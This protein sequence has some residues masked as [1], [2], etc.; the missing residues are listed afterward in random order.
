MPPECVSLTELNGQRER[1]PWFP[2]AAVTCGE[3]EGVEYFKPAEGG[4]DQ[5]GG[6][7]GDYVGGRENQPHGDVD[8]VDAPP[9]YLDPALDDLE[10]FDPE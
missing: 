1:Y 2:D 3:F 5:G 7:G 4:D 10:G 9:A 8:D 6:G